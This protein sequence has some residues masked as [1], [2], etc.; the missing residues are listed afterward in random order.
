MDI[1]STLLSDLFLLLDHLLRG[2]RN[3]RNVGTPLGWVR[4]V[5]FCLTA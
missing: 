3:W 2:D 5:V 4:W 1:L